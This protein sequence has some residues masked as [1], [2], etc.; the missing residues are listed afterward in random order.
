MLAFE[1]IAKP[2]LFLHLVAA[3]CALASCIHLLLRLITAARRGSYT[4]QVK[5]H[6]RILFISYAVVFTLGGMLYPTY[7]IRIRKDFL[8]S[9]VPFVQPLFELK[10]HFASVGMMA[11]LGTLVLASLV[12]FKKPDAKAYV[13]LWIGLLVVI[14]AVLGYNTVTGWYISTLRSI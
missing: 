5:M 7:R 12:D 14:L 1:S 6:T 4:G 8:E 13:P 9:A 3:A 10:E 11:A 2:L